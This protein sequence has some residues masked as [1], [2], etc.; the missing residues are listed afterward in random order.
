MNSYLIINND[1]VIIETEEK[2]IIKEEK[3]EDASIS[4]YDLTETELKNAIEDLDTYTFLSSKKIVIIREIESININDNL[5]DLKHL[6]KYIENP[7]IDNLLIIEVREFKNK[8]EEKSQA[9]KEFNLEKELKKAC[10]T[11][12]I[13]L[14]PKSY[15]KSMFKGYKISSNAI[16]LLDEYCQED[17]TKLKNECEKLKNYKYDS[18]EI[19]EKDIKEMVQKKLTDPKNLTFSFARN[20]G[21]RN[22]Q[23]SL[24]DYHELLEYNVESLQIIGLLASQ[25]RIIYQVKLLSRRGLRDNEI[26]NML[27]EKEFRVK[28][29][30]E[31][32]SLYSE[33]DL[34]H[35]MQELSNIDLRIKTTDT[36]PISEIE[37][38]ITNI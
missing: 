7:S 35:L 37:L 34:L 15:I 18:K 12:E 16:D 30:K 8:K 6:I 27:E 4:I 2:R 33:K 19:E 38:F 28:K 14:N 17:Y 3:F 31:L 9:K 32:I 36:N 26:A 1:Y 11:Q 23:K 5:E 21:E 13:E 22:I 29:T 10:K 20:L 25:F 24:Q